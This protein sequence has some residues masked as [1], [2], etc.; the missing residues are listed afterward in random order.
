MHMP[1]PFLCV[2]WYFLQS[3]DISCLFGVKKPTTDTLQ[4]SDN[5]LYISIMYFLLGKLI[6][7]KKK[8]LKREDAGFFSFLCKDFFLPRFYSTFIFIKFHASA[9]NNDFHM[10]SKISK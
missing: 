9:F 4:G 2:K 1:I 5:F 10:G 7:M 8:G 6:N 3:K